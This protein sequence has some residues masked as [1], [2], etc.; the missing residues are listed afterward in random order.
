MLH[1]KTMA[2]CI[3]IR[4]YSSDSRSME[5]IEGVCHKITEVYRQKV[6]SMMITSEFNHNKD[7][8][9]TIQYPHQTNTA[10][11]GTSM[12]PRRL[13]FDMQ[14]Y[15]YPPRTNLDHLKH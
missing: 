8:E 14:P 10:M 7:L 4:G 15:F 6:G 2:F 11:L 9:E 1:V 12:Q 3:T 5:R 13:I